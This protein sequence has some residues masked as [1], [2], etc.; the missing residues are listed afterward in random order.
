M[1]VC[2]DKDQRRTAKK[3]GL[4]LMTIQTISPEGG[5]ITYQGC[6]TKKELK[7]IDDC[8][9]RLIKIAIGKKKPK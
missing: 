6:A 7:I 1:R 5:K 8:R 3:K 2:Y 4:G 9:T